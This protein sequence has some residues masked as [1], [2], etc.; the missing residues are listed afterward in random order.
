MS[1]SSKL[2]ELEVI[3]RETGL[4]DS[5][6]CMDEGAYIL[7]L[8]RDIADEVALLEINRTGLQTPTSLTLQ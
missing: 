1:I 6:D 8:L 2:D 7:G 3:M 5:I 4:T